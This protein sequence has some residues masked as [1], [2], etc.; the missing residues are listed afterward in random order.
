MRCALPRTGDAPL[1]ADVDVLAKCSTQ[2][3]G[4]REY[5]RWHALELYQDVLGPYILRIGYCTSWQGE[6]GYDWAARVGDADAVRAA[7]RD[8]DCTAYVAGF[9]PGQA[10]AAKQERLLDEIEH[11]YDLAVSAVLGALVEHLQRMGA[12]PLRDEATP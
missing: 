11:R 12:P 8:H 1:V 2:R 6:H 9:P 3:L 10:Y 7:R 4:G 5:A